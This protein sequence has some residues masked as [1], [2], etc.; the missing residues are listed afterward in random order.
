VAEISS[1]VIDHNGRANANMTQER[2][3]LLFALEGARTYREYI[4]V[5]GQLDKLP[6]DLG[7][8]GDEWRQDEGSDAYDA[9]LCRIYLAVMRAAREGGDVPALGL[10]LRTVLHRNFAG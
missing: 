5:A 7:E 8:G 3:K 2:N 6:A 1:G 9:A 4:S 10:A